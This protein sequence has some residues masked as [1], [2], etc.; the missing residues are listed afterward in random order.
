MYKSEYAPRPRKKN[1]SVKSYHEEATFITNFQVHRLPIYMAAIKIWD[2]ENPSQA[3]DLFIVDEA[4][5]KDGLLMKES[6]SFH[7]KAQ[8]SQNLGPFWKIWED[9]GGS[10]AGSIQKE[11]IK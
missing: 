1:E 11:A 6:R 4:V 5:N 2:E 3:G 7:S 8:R 9:L 10:E